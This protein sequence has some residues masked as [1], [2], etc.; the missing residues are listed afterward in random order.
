MKIM[1]V[2]DMHVDYEYEPGTIAE[3]QEPM[4]CRATSTP[5]HNYSTPGA[6]YWGD[7]RK[8]EI[9]KWAMVDMLRH[10]NVTH[11]SDIDYIY[12]GGDLPPHDVWNQSKIIHS[13]LIE[14]YSSIFDHWFP[15]TPVFYTFGNHEVAP[16]NMY[17]FPNTPDT[18]ELSD[19]WLYDI[20]ADTWMKWLDP[21]IANRT[22]R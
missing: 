16:V 8:C 18:P 6:G 20:A 3:C 9:P 1:M 22:L 15:G 5:K 10:A 21:E 11:G 7:Y 2:T 4:C 19:Q 13:E 14:W 12:V 17:T